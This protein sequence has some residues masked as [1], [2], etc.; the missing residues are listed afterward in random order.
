[1]A[2]IT[3][4]RVRIGIHAAINNKARFAKVSN[5]PYY[6]YL[7]DTFGS[8]Y[9]HNMKGKLIKESEKTIEYDPK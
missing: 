2:K 4:Q 7:L 5:E 3:I 9:I 6:I 8:A 1:M